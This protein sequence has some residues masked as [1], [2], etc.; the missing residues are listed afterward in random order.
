MNL[1]P[2]NIIL[3]FF[4]FADF[5]CYKPPLHPLLSGGEKMEGGPSFQEGKRK[6]G[7]SFQEGKRWKVDP[8]FVKISSNP[9]N[10][11]LIPP[12]SKGDWGGF[13]RRESRRGKREGGP[14]F[15]EG[16]ER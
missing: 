12:F 7:P 13:K 10:P 15:Q 4:P 14:S 2:V 8:P 16:K 1:T 9:P 3:Y 6:G 11:P 5:P